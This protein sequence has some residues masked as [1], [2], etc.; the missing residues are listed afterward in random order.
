MD[1]GP[2]LQRM[3][4]LCDIAP[5]DLD[6]VS[7]AAAGASAYHHGWEHHLAGLI[8]RASCPDRLLALAFVTDAY[9]KFDA[10]PGEAPGSRLEPVI[11]LAAQAARCRHPG[12]APVLRALFVHWHRVGAVP[13]SL[14]AAACSEAEPLPL[15]PPPLP[16]Q[17]HPQHLTSITPAPTRPPTCR[18]CA[19]TFPTAFRLGVHTALHKHEDT[20]ETAA[21]AGK[22]SRRRLPRGWILNEDGT[23]TA[24]N[25]K[26]IL[27][28]RALDG[29]VSEA[30]RGAHTVVAVAVGPSGQRRCRDRCSVCGDEFPEAKPE[31]CE[32]GT[33]RAWVLVR[34][35]CTH[36]AG[37]AAALVHPECISP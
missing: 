11:A 27:Y 12:H 10:E 37:C 36:I 20:L 8:A 1:T 14:C 2:P 35:A 28:R 32:D 19:A 17:P 3:A 33:G 24:S 7:I 29:H 26:G 25:A 21:A 30:V 22:A 31:P 4:F 34:D 6:A 13:A 9:L 5:Q 16:P 23:Q 18:L 15:P